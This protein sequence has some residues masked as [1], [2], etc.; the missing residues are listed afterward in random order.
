VKDGDF[1]KPMSAI[2]EPWV[3]DKHYSIQGYTKFKHP[4]NPT[5]LDEDGMDSHKIPFDAQTQ[6]ASDNLAK[7]QGKVRA[8]LVKLQ[9]PAAET[10]KKLFDRT[11]PQHT[12]ARLRALL[13][14]KFGQAQEVGT[15][16]SRTE[17]EQYEDCVHEYVAYLHEQLL[18]L[19]ERLTLAAHT[20][21]VQ[22]YDLQT[23]KVQ[24]VAPQLF[25]RSRRDSSVAAD[26]MKV[27]KDP[28][29]TVANLAEGSAQRAQEAR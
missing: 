21:L 13:T 11:D 22:D 1:E 5:G 6:K 4:A 17:A 12:P 14:E 26:R 28:K 16:D 15:P 25:T 7:E 2:S 20:S 27:E 19:S 8:L 3:R 23:Q 18:T 24:A 9:L 29:L 10:A